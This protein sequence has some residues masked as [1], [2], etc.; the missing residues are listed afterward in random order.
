M[1]R[2]SLVYLII[3]KFTFKLITRNTRISNLLLAVLFTSAQK[4][5]TNKYRAIIKGFILLEAVSFLKLLFQLKLQ[6]VNL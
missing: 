4:A 2:G 5:M 1:L 6:I 3:F